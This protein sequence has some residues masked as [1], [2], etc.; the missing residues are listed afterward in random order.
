[1]MSQKAFGTIALGLL[2]LFFLAGCPWSSSA[3]VFD[4]AKGLS[5]PDFNGPPA[6][7]EPPIA[8]EEPS[9]LEL[10]RSEND[11]E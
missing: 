7:S 6:Q 8:E 4:G 3:N 2:G 9:A 1:M 10:P 11:F 5:M